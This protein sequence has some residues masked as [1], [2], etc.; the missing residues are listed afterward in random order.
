MALPTLKHDVF[1][2]LEGRS[3][4]FVGGLPMEPWPPSSLSRV[5]GVTLSQPSNLFPLCFPLL[6]GNLPRGLRSEKVQF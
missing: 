4:L 6:L 3:H 5:E 2:A 1:T